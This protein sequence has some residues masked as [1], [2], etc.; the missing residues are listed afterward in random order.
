MDPQ[1]DP[2]DATRDHFLLATGS[3]I[4]LAWLEDDDAVGGGVSCEDTVA[5]SHGRERLAWSGL[6]LGLG[7]GLGWAT[8]LGG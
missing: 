5:S 7:L 4:N 6:G 8:W 3:L 1:V 2:Q